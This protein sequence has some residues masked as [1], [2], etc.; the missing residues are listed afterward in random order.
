MHDPNRTVVLFCFLC[1]DRL[2]RS[3]IASFVLP[4]ERVVLINGLA[5]SG[6]LRI[7]SS[8]FEANAARPSTDA[9]CRHWVA[10]SAPDEAADA[11]FVA[12]HGRAYAVPC[13]HVR[14][15][16]TCALELLVE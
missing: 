1:T 13:G 2:P 7:N 8:A 12:S 16:F 14:L 9:A 4:S 15:M 3:K 5:L 6:R 11:G 10:C